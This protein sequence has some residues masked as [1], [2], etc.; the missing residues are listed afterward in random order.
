MIGSLIEKCPN[1][2]NPIFNETQKW[3]DVYDYFTAENED[4]FGIHFG[5]VTFGRIILSLVFY[6]KIQIKKTKI[7][8]QR[9]NKHTENK[10]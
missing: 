6:T 9:K 8:K 1:L 10:F 7:S 2:L 3:Y 5:A 4:K